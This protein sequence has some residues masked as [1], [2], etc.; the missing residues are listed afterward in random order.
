M[1]MI[2][3]GITGQRKEFSLKKKEKIKASEKYVLD[4]DHNGLNIMTMPS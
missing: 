1:G 2:N 4:P 3:V